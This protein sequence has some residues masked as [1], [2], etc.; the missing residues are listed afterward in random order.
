[1]LGRPIGRFWSAVRNPGIW[2]ASFCCMTFMED[3]LS[4]MN[5]T[6][7]LP[8]L[9]PVVAAVTAADAGGTEGSTFCWA[10]DAATNPR[11][12]ATPADM[13]D[14]VGWRRRRARSRNSPVSSRPEAP[15]PAG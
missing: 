15:V 2:E 11:A 7:R 1:M 8:G 14:T 12:I 10:Q 3:E 9:G 13:L 4:I 5:R 6:S